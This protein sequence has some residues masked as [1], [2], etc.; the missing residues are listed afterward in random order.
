MF[1]LLVVQIEYS[2]WKNSVNVT[3]KFFVKVCDTV[4]LLD[5]RG[6]YP[7]HPSNCC[8]PWAEKVGFKRA[9]D[10]SEVS[11]MRLLV[12]VVVHASVVFE[13]VETTMFLFDLGEGRS[14]RGGI[15]WICCKV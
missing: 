6:V 12:S 2:E 14:D 1:A 9:L 15:G 5:Y 4:Q 8:G 3:C 13:D 10:A 7:E 11:G